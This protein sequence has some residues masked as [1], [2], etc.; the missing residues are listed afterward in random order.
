MHVLQKSFDAATQVYS[1]P[2]DHWPCPRT[3]GLKRLRAEIKRR[4][5]AVDA[6]PMEVAMGP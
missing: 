1:L 3:N 5:R 6:F 2:Q 4:I